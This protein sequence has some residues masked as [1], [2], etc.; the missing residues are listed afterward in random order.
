[1]SDPI[2]PPEIEYT[3]FMDALAIKGTS[4]SPRNLLLVA[5][6]VHT[7][8]IPKLTETFAIRKFAPPQ[9]YPGPSGWSIDTL[10][11]H[12]IHTR[13]LFIWTSPYPSSDCYDPLAAKYISLCPN[14]TNLVLWSAHSM[15]IPYAQL[16]EI[17]HL[18]SL[19]HLSINLKK[20]PSLAW[21]NSELL[22]LFEKIT[23]L[24][25]VAIIE[26]SKD[27][28]LFNHFTSLTHLTFPDLSDET[29]IPL[30]LTRLPTLEALIVLTDHPNHFSRISVRHDCQWSVDDPR[31]VKIACQS[32]ADKEL[33][34][35]LLEVQERRGIWGLADRAIR[36]RQK[37]KGLS[38]V[39]E[40][41]K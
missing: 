3:I 12:G 30:F 22:R 39:A 17:A 33:D 4:E 11:T 15:E 14:L 28:T 1:M 35:W 19:T 5:K 18:H 9:N 36:E 25:N 8:L 23:H 26:S 7:W 10:I 27:I 16:N 21:E 37:Q 29:L 13:N 6:R 24:H 20:I 32:Y 31:I 34:E 41:D 40:E 2:L 38:V